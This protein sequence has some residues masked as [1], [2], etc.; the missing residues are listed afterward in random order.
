MATFGQTIKTLRKRKGWTQDELGAKVGLQKSA[1]AKYENGKIE[2]IT[3][4]TTEKFA[5]AFGVS[6]HD[7]LEPFE[8][9]LYALDVVITDT[10]TGV[11]LSIPDTEACVEYSSAT[12]DGICAARDYNTVWADLGV[13]EKAH[14]TIVNVEGLTAD[15]RWLVEYVMSLSD[16]EVKHLRGL[17]EFVRS[18]RG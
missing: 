8:S 3:T 14:D 12:W 6:V 4:A 1:I 7:L 2:N 13:R 9:N 16:D 11:K 18:Q 15:K 10:R 5:T 17:V